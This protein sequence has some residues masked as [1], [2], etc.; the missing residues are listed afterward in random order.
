MK[1]K[2]RVLIIWKGKSFKNEIKEIWVDDK[3]VFLKDYNFMQKEKEIL[4]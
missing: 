2:P 4:I 3:Q 1:K